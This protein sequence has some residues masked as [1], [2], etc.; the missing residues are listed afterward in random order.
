MTNKQDRI[1][2]IA[3]SLLMSNATS[4]DE[5]MN[6]NDIKVAIMFLYCDDR[7][8]VVM[9]CSGHKDVPYI[10]R[11]VISLLGQPDKIIDSMM[12][13]REDDGAYK[14]IKIVSCRNESSM[15]GF[16][17]E[18][19]FYVD[20]KDNEGWTEQLATSFWLD[21]ILY[22]GKYLITGSFGLVDVYNMLIRDGMTG[23]HALSCLSNEDFMTL[24][25]ISQWEL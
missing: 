8:Q 19:L 11:Q 20:Y 5:V 17:N 13:Y 15:R 6:T 1:N 18:D 3:Y 25:G 24:P 23:D 16:R 21:R 10:K 7:P 9:Q 14:V 22:L 4:D 2:A 12:F